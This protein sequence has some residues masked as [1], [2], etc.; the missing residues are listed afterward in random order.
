MSIN[1]DLISAAYDDDFEK[2]KELIKKGANVN[3]TE[4]NQKNTPLHCTSLKEIAEFLISN[5]AD[6]NIINDY[7]GCTPLVNSIIRK[8]K[9]VANLLISK[10]ADIHIKNESGYTPLHCAASKGWKEMVELL[11]SKGAD[12]NAKSNDG[13]TP[14]D[15]ASEEGQKEIVELLISKGA[16]RGR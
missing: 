10:G 14:L 13:R 1:T 16:K 6:L 2:V 4:N 8:R 9:E 7:G 5:G 12:L 11:I 3:T 15:R